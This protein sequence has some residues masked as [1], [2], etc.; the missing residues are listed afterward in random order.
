[1]QTEGRAVCVSVCVCV[2]VCVSCVSIY[3]LNWPPSACCVQRQLLRR[4]ALI[5]LLKEKRSADVCFHRM[6]TYQHLN[7]P[8]GSTCEI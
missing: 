5:T 4:L 8:F 1:M 3:M 7:V 6:F 2:C